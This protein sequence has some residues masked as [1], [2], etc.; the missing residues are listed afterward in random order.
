MLDKI[1]ISSVVEMWGTYDERIGIK[2]LDNRVIFSREITIDKGYF[3]VD[4]Y[5][6]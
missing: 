5:N 6:E 3:V 1:E 2:L 4:F